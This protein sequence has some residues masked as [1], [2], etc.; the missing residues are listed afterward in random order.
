MTSET[1]DNITPLRPERQASAREFLAVVFRRKWIILGLFVISVLTVFTI[2][3]T[4]PT[5]Y[6]SIGKVLVNRGEKESLMIPQRRITN[7]EEELAS[8]VQFIESHPVAQRAQAILDEEA[9]HGGRKLTLNAALVDAEVV[10]ASNALLIAYTDPDPTVAQTMCD[11]MIRAY[12]DT[13]NT[14]FNLTYPQEFFSQETGQVMDDL[15]RLERERRDYAQGNHAV[16]LDNQQSSQVNYLNILDQRRNELLSKLASE[17]TQKEQLDRFATDP[18]LDVPSTGDN[19]EQVLTDIKL[20]IMQQQARVAQLREKYRDDSPDVVNATATLET[21]RA[22]ARR[23]LSSRADMSQTRIAM[24]ESQLKPIDTEI[25]RVRSDL[26]TMPQ[27][28]MSMSE[29]DRQIDLLRDRYSQLVR[30]GDQARVTQE[31]SRTVTVLVLTPAGP[32][33]PT[34]TRD[35]VRLGLAPAFSLVVGLGLAFFIDG[36][37]TRV[38]TAGD[39]EAAAELPVLA[40]L[41]EHRRR[42]TDPSTGGEAA[43][44]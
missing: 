38:R 11:A 7:W 8:E 10:G 12:V 1:R 6:R 24:L 27:K 25:A 29:L 16:A 42:R 32:G 28:Q 22:M 21:L 33:R 30:L 18:T 17:R 41:S 9:R 19:G 37:D 40:S 26:S 13:R 15:S 3:L 5:R 44:R 34:N 43:S 20:K 14:T 4:S 23:E 31:M 39:A 36:L 35:Y 2:T